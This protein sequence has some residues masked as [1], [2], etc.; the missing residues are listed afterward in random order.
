MDRTDLKI[1]DLL[2]HDATLST[3]EVAE[4]VGLSTTPCW[5]RIQNLE[6]EGVITRRVALLDRDHLNVGMDAF[7]TIRTNQHNRRWLEAFASAVAAFPEVIEL[8]RMSGDV[9][10]LMRVVVPDIAAYDDFY[11]R[12]IRSIDLSDVSS[13]FAMER[14]K[15]TTVL[16]LKHAPRRTAR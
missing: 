9:D 2:Q 13:S 12:L 14:I 15:Y 16:P 6:K 7:V 3:A 10:Y 8:Y 5:R 4:A 1:L 11:Q